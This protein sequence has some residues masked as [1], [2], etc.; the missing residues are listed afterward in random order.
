MEI[1]K[2]VKLLTRKKALLKRF[3][4]CELP[5]NYASLRGETS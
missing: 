2:I 1:D 5:A 4:A 3:A